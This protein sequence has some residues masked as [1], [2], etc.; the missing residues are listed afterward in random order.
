[1]F[2][3]LGLCFRLYHLPTQPGAWASP[4]RSLFLSSTFPTVALL[5]QLGIWRITSREWDRTSRA[6]PDPAGV[7]SCPSQA[8]P[9]CAQAQS[10]VHAILLVLSCFSPL[11]IPA[12][13]DT[14]SSALSQASGSLGIT[15]MVVKEDGEGKPLGNGAV[16]V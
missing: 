11:H 4:P 10:K 16:W 6:F 13:K 7:A 15:R 9:S 3:F 8:G 14:P 5:A 1:M 12:P 2:A